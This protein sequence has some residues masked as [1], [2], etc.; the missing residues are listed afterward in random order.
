MAGS[1]GTFE[2]EDVPAMPGAEGSGGTAACARPDDAEPKRVD[3]RTIPVWRWAALLGAAL[4]VVAAGAVT[5][6]TTITGAEVAPFAAALYPLML[7]ALGL[8]VWWYPGARYRRLR[9][10]VSDAG[11]EI[12]SGIVWRTRSSLP[13]VRIQHTDIS[14]GPIQRRYG[15]A[16][17]K[18]YTAGSRFTLIEL[19]GLAHAT[20]VALR[21]RLLEQGIGD[22]V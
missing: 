2:S 20:A 8:H 19:P 1:G 10:R 11:L 5:L 15:V 7:L 18:L 16:T 14:Q 6:I 17:L 22:A 3:P 13:R 9:Y 21:D 4:P 12:E